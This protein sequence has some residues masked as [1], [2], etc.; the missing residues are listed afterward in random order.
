MNR[1]ARGAHRLFEGIPE[2]VSDIFRNHFTWFACNAEDF[3]L[4][5]ACLGNLLLA[6]GYLRNNRRLSPVID[7]FSGM[8]R[9]RGLVRPVVE[10]SAH[11][12]VRLQSGEVIV[13]QHRFAGKGGPPLTAPIASVWLA[14]SEDAPTP[15]RIA[16]QPEIADMISNADCLCYP[17]GSFYSSVV[18]NLLPQGVGRAVAKNSGPKIFVPN[19]GTD[20]ELA[21]HSVRD[22]VELLTAIIRADA[23]GARLSDALTHILADPAWDRYPGGIPEDWLRGQGVHVVSQPLVSDSA[24]PLADPG[25][26]APALLRLAEVSRNV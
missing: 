20:P 10:D 21:G 25:L 11:L 5:G 6:T 16:I 18:A 9:A 22:Q 7:F 4:A 13:G 23:P 19:L 17:V 2:S 14:E 15:A 8:V 26:L 3:C 24:T 12:A 1:L